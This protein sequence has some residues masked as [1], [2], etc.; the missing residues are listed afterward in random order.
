MT[1]LSVEQQKFLAAAAA[2]A[3]VE[4]KMIVGLGTGST[5]E[6]AIRLLAKKVKAGLKVTG[7]PTSAATEKLARRLKIPL[8]DDLGTFKKIDLT[9]DGADE[10][11][12]Q[13]NLIKGGGGAL[14]REKIVASRSDRFIIIVDEKKLVKQ[15]GKFPLPVEILPFGW[16]STLEILRDL[17]A[18]VKLRQIDVGT[19]YRTDNG[20][21]ILDC[22]FG[23]MA[24]PPALAQQI[25]S[26]AGVVDVGLFISRADLVLAGHHN[27]RIEEKWA[28]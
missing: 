9:I 11:D 1:K 8:V 17:G 14:A 12:P 7:V 10:V 28:A 5:T 26:I 2:I 19:P 13:L 22:A 27:G 25:K 16:R 3:F 15:L 20:N 4:N 18:R 24:N 23:K 21:Y 6:F